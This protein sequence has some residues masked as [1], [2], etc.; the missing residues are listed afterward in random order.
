[1]LLC[2]IEMLSEAE[3][4]QLLYDFNDTYADYPREKTI[5]QLF[6]E[7]VEKT[8]GNVALLFN[9]SSMTYDELNK[10][11]NQLAWLLR[12]R[13]VKADSIVAIMTE[14][15][16]E[17][18][19]GI[20]GILKAG[21]AYLPIDPEY[22]E[23]RIEF[24]LND[25]G[26][27]ILLAQTKLSAKF[28]L[29]KYIIGL[30]DS[31]TYTG[32]A[33][34]LKPI[35]NANNLSYLIYTSGSTG[36]PKA[37][38]IEHSAIVNRLN[39]MQK[40]YP[41][42]EEDVILQ[43]TTYTFDV[44]LWE[45]LW[46]CFAGARTCLLEQGKEKDPQTLI[47]EIERSKVTVMHFVPSMLTMFL[48]HIDQY[49]VTNGLETL[50]MVFASGE[51][52]TVQQV[53]EFN[54]NIREVN[55]T[56]LINL[57]G[58]TEAAVDVTYF[59][60]STSSFNKS[61]P[62]GKPIDNTSLYVLDSNDMLCP[63]GIE[64]ELNISGICLARGYLNR[65]EL[66]AEKFVGNPF[67]S[68]ERLYKTGDLVRWLS[69]GNI[70]FLGRI[71][72]QVKIRGF[73][74]ELG[75][76]EY[77]LLELGVINEV[78][79]MAKEDDRGDKYLCAYV[80]SDNE[81]QAGELRKQ[82][83]DNLPDYM[84]PSYFVQLDKLPLMP[85]GK[86]DRKA[87]PKPEGGVQNDY[88]APR[89]TVEE[90]LVQIWADV[91][92]CEKVGISDNFFELGGHSLK[93]I[94][95]LNRMNSELQV[96]IPLSEL[97]ANPYISHIAEYINVAQEDKYKNVDGLFLLRGEKQ[98]N[99][100]LFFVHSGS[101]RA[102]AYMKLA[103]NMDDKFNCWGIDYDKLDA[104]D[105]CVMP[106]KELA[107]IYVEKIKQIQERGPYCISG[108]CLGGVIAFE[109]AR[110]LEADNEEISFLGL[111][112]SPMVN[113]GK[114][115]HEAFMKPEITL[116]TEFR[117]IQ[118]LFNEH[119]FLEKYREITSLEDL[120]NKIACDLEG[121]VS[122]EE[123]REKIFDSICLES[124]FIRKF[125]KDHTKVKI[126]DI[127]HHFNL[128]RGLQNNFW[129][130]RSKEKL[131]GKITYYI[132]A[133]EEERT[134]ALWKELS[135]KG[136]DYYSIDADHFSMF[137]DDEDVKKLAVTLRGSLNEVHYLESTM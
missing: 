80:I 69:D 108:W 70:E 26:A 12:D 103:N 15:S 73:R 106:I 58:P 112:N 48:E 47:Q 94:T 99:M 114:K 85:N 128:L 79:V 127:L 88:I 111:Y 102:V 132:A 98:T 52:L 40:A 134:S 1:T 36:K 16:F 51:A 97:Y 86:V 100:N 21:G 117:L 125:I 25:S 31:S 115:L 53:S 42:S 118:K 92:G 113:R 109:M 83:S 6:E 121:V 41:L 2:D 101:G 72:S 122:Y 110:Q 130:Y 28:T 27:D 24:M 50:R 136:V 38:M 20:L 23:D 60:A 81:I 105:P 19:I 68:D 78:I 33:G 77:R 71:D 14:R 7:Q 96:N 82:L 61:I 43:K 11:S 34:N 54:R 116:K 67:I 32:D 3:R 107:A 63:I 5:H 104:Y 124:H 74:I 137:E 57:Y 17:M 22:P 46:W 37:V 10:R 84:I 45:L 66:T 89:N 120:W 18:I 123:T 119:I 131:K 29:D 135:R 59:N 44:S 55:G 90:V 64:G 129:W 56:E 93:A 30:D 49:R 62:I 133:R 126:S 39:W 65:P 95:L 9:G 76:I 8:P 75:E 91:L 13:G 35:C 4:N 87:L